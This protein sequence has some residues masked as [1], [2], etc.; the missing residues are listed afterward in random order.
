MA[1]DAAGVPTPVVPAEGAEESGAPVKAY[2]Y[3]LTPEFLVVLSRPER[4]A[5]KEWTSFGLTTATRLVARADK[6]VFVVEGKSVMETY[7]S[8]YRLVIKD[9]RLSSLCLLPRDDGT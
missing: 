5:F 3:P 6:G 1:D 7:S 8:Y 2:T 4:D 9:N